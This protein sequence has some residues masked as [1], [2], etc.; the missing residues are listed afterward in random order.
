MQ[1]FTK[2]MRMC[3]ATWYTDRRGMVRRCEFVPM[4]TRENGKL[5][6]KSAEDTKGTKTCGVASSANASSVNPP[7]TVRQFPSACQLSAV[8]DACI[9]R[10][11]RDSVHFE[12][13]C[14]TRRVARVDLCV[15]C[16]QRLS[17]SGEPAQT[18]SDPSPLPSVHS[19]LLGMR[20]ELFYRTGDASSAHLRELVSLQA[21]LILSQQEELLQRNAQLDVLSQE[22]GQVSVYDHT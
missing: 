11:P 7:E 21:D 14:Y 16:G 1:V 8:E 6:T 5:W 22:K 19:R 18:S 10:L 2:L 12:D 20:E 3:N 17:G 15:K 4:D 13:H 9:I